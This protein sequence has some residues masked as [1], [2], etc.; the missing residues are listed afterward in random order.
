MI[1][2]QNALPYTKC[3]KISL[4][5]AKVLKKGLNQLFKCNVPNVN[6]QYTSTTKRDSKEIVSLD[7]YAFPT[8]REHNVVLKGINESFTDT[9]P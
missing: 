3:I 1:L 7:K 4:Q 2:L 6:H 9:S 5:I 8:P